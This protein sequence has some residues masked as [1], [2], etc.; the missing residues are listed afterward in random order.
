MILGII[1]TSP[2]FG[3]KKANQQQIELLV[4]GK[5]ADLWIMPELALT[6]YEFRNRAEAFEYAEEILDGE[7]T[8]WL[9]EFCS[10]RNC[11]AV[12]GLPERE[13]K[14]VFNSA[15]VVGQEG[16]IGRYRKLHLFDREKERFD[17]GNLLLQVF[18][19]GGAKI[20]L[21]ICFD[22]RFPEVARTLTL[23]GAQILAH[24]S[25]LVIP[26]CQHAMITRSLENGVFCAT[27]NRI[28]TETRAGRSVTFT[29]GSQLV[30]PDGKILSSASTDCSACL[31]F[32]INPAN[33]DSKQA[34]PHN[35]LLLDRRP[36]FYL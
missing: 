18:D 12:L 7:S 15:I 30:A 13:G 26:Y 27:V 1:Q 2:A 3:D 31:V 19:I 24:P 29:G 34:T 10:K 5:H 20:G 4:E 28:G 35:H 16:L 32:E 8:K 23:R 25:N 11:H 36:E 14:S 17:A 21:M 6:G 9:M 33:A 22:W